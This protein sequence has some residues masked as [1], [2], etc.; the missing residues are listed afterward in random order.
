MGRPKGR[1]GQTVENKKRELIKQYNKC[2]K[3]Q[4]RKTLLEWLKQIK[5]P[6]KSK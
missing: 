5:E 1:S 4:Q 3:L 2:K 6:N